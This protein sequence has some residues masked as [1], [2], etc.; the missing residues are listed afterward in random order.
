MDEIKKVSKDTHA[1]LEKVD[2]NTWCQGWFNTY[3]KSGLLS[4]NTCE[5]FNSWIKKY[6]DQTI[7]T[8]LEEIRCKLMRRYVREKK[9]IN[10]IKKALG[11]KIKKKLAKEKV[12]ATN[13]FYIY[14]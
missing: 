1:Y 10:S 12:E 4:N 7:L 13:C 2:P 6:R 8:M 14:A 11:P 3:A 9:M 5:S